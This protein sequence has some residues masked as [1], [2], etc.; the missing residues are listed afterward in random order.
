MLLSAAVIEPP[1]PIKEFIP[2][3]EKHI[4]ASWQSDAFESEF[5][6]PI[7]SEFHSFIRT[8]FSIEEFKSFYLREDCPK[9]TFPLSDAKA[10]SFKEAIQSR[11]FFFTNYESIESTI[12]LALASELIL[13]KIDKK[14]YYILYGSTFEKRPRGRI[15]E[16]SDNCFYINL[17]WHLINEILCIGYKFNEILVDEN[18]IIAIDPKKR[19]SEGLFEQFANQQPVIFDQIALSLAG[20]TRGEQFRPR[21]LIPLQLGNSDANILIGLLAIVFLILH[22]LSHFLVRTEKSAGELHKPYYEFFERTVESNADRLSPIDRLAA[23][24]YKHE[25]LKKHS[26]EFSADLHA[27]IE[28][29][30]IS[31]ERLQNRWIGLFAG[32]MVLSIFALLDRFFTFVTTGTDVVHYVGLQKYNQNYFAPDYLLTKPSH[33]WGKTRFDVI[34][35]LGYISLKSLCNFSQAESAEFL[36]DY[37]SVKRS[38]YLLNSECD[39]RLSRILELVLVFEGDFSVQIDTDRSIRLF[40]HSK[41]KPLKEYYLPNLNYTN[42]PWCDVTGLR[43]N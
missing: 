1:L 35:Y 39:W 2:I 32:F 14:N 18:G 5:E 28:V 26:E 7:I 27:F 12:I 36:R 19:L 42:V 10:L 16:L 11:R 25:Y 17:G 30:F 38:A 20:I 43:A 3:A 21:H 23:R 4:K 31:Y 24:Y 29:Y 13:K 6:K 33:P 41:G 15:I 9:C 34:A 8:D 22:E 40:V 37:A